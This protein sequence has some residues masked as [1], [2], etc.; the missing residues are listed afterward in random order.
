MILEVN[1]KNNWKLILNMNW[2]FRNPIQTVD[3]PWFPEN[4]N[5]QHQEKTN[6]TNK[7]NNNTIKPTKKIM[8]QDLL[9]PKRN[10]IL[11]QASLDENPLPSISASIVLPTNNTSTPTPSSDNTSTRKYKGYLKRA[12]TLDVHDESSRDELSLY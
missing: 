12:M 3:G 7:P 5:H 9:S 2:C 6:K 8:S 4:N 10:K 1:N 11:R